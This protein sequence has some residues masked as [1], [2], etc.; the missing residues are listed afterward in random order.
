MEKMSKV[1]EEVITR[2]DNDM[3]YPIGH[4]REGQLR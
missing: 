2:N 3:F 4:V 1:L